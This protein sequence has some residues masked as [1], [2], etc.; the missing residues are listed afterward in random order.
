[1]TTAAM[2]RR[3]SSQPPA[4]EAWGDPQDQAWLAGATLLY[5]E[6]D[7]EALEVTGEFLRRRVGTLVTAPDGALGLEAFRASRPSIV[8]TDIRMPVLDG[9]AMAEGIRGLD[10]GVPIIVTTAFERPEYLARSIAIGIDHYVLKPVQGHL[11]DFALRTCARRASTRGQE[12]APS[13]TPEEA[14]R[15][16]ALSARER[17]ILRWIGHGLPA[18]EIGINLEIS[19]KTVRA[20][21][22][23]LMLK[24]DLH[25]STAL[26]ALAIRAGLI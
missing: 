16:E 21:V 24:L 10:A 5:V 19:P 23:H 6:D 14:A 12:A 25:K 4:Q 11:L 26:A 17:E 20:H 9:L 3:P 22:A 15:L 2:N 13:L 18:A 8:V 1:M 7:A